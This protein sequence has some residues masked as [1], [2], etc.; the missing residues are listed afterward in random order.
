[1][2]GLIGELV[3]VKKKHKVRIKIEAVNQIIFIQI[4]KNKLRVIS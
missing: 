2:T 3:E 4:P 1:M